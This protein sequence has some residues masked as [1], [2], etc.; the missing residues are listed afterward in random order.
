MLFMQWL[1]GVF[2][3]VFVHFCAHFRWKVGVGGVD[4]AGMWMLA[5]M[6]ISPFGWLDPLC[7]FGVELEAGVGR[8]FSGWMLFGL[9]ALGVG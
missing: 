3:R 5:G 2:L 7:A 8:D 9:L 4:W 1:P 6:E